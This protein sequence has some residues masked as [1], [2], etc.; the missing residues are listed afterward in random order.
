MVYGSPRAAADGSFAYQ[1]LYLR[2][3]KLSFWVFT[4]VRPLFFVICVLPHHLFLCVANTMGD[5]GSFLSLGVPDFGTQEPYF[6]DKD[7]HD[8]VLIHADEQL[9][10][11]SLQTQSVQQQEAKTSRGTVLTPA[12]LFPASNG[13]GEDKTE[14]LSDAEQQPLHTFFCVHPGRASAAISPEEED[15]LMQRRWRADAVEVE[16]FLSQLDAAREECAA[17]G[18][19]AKAQACMK[20]M[21]HAVRLFAKRLHNEADDVAA[22]TRQRMA[23]QHQRERLE[24]RKAW[25]DGVAA[26][27]RNA[28]T[29]LAATEQHHHAQL[30]KEDVAMRADLQRGNCDSGGADRDE[31]QDSDAVGGSAW[32]KE[33][34]HLQMELRQCL[35]QRRYPDAERVRAQLQR[36]EKQEATNHQRGVTRRHLQR[37]QALKAAQASAVAEM[38]AVQRQE[39]QEMARAGRAALDELTQRHLAAEQSVEERRMH[40]HTRTREVLREY[41]YADVLDPKATGLKLIRLSQLLWVPP[42]GTV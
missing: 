14:P 22:R 7:K 39:L 19:Y 25:R 23:A 8:A 32:S 28:A 1:S 40:L 33:T 3:L 41:E 4:F 6:R 18:L 35:R 17:A 26:Y 10:S 12:A 27:K 9:P 29:L 37:L 30:V 21:E 42:S 13:E 31:T 20:R 15:A 5:K 2:H 34:Q 16:S 24:L 36:L 11:T 38:Q